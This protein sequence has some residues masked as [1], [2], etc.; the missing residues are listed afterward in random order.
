MGPLHSCGKGTNL[1]GHIC[2]D[3]KKNLGVDITA[4]QFQESER[5]RQMIRELA[6]QRELE[7]ELEGGS[8]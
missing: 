3:F 2:R 8:S 5:K 7:C 6:T 4:I 1:A